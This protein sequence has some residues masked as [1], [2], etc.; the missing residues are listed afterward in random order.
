[1]TAQNPEC[2]QRHW[3]NSRIFPLIP[4]LAIRKGNEHNTNS[5][6]FEWLFFRIWSLDAFEFEIAF[7]IGEHWGIGITAI[8][9]Y[10]RIVCCIPCPPKLA[11]WCMDKLWRKPHR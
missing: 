6:C 9:P 8:L 1:M 10:L 11:M 5:F 2:K 7:N 4:V 3:Y